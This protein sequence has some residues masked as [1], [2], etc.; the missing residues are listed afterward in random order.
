VLIVDD[1]AAM[2]ALLRVII[3]AAG[4]AIAGEAADGREA[5]SLVKEVQPDLITMDLDMPLVNGAAATAEIC[6]DGC[7]PIVIVSGSQ[8]S[9]LVGAALDAGAR[10]HVAKRDAA[11]E[12]PQVLHSLLT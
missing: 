1:D 10:W 2:R 11:A 7:V 6:S 3:E 5:V 12:L 4:F 8:S 9:D